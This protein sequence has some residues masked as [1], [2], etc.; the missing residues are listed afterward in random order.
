MRQSIHNA[1]LSVV[2]RAMK[3][4]RILSGTTDGYWHGNRQ[5]GYHQ[6]QEGATS[7]ALFQKMQNG[8][9]QENIT[10][11]RMVIIKNMQEWGEVE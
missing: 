7:A 8:L 11:N 3:R 4:T 9:S 5:I 1:Q 10:E 2:Y 6:T